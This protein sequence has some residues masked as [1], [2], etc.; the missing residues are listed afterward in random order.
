MIADATRS[1]AASILDANGRLPEQASALRSS[2]NSS[3]SLATTDPVVT[4]AM[5][6]ETPDGNFTYVEDAVWYVMKVVGFVQFQL[7]VADEAIVEVV[8]IES[9]G[10]TNQTQQ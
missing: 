5:A 6:A 3:N 4:V 2:I 9:V 8:K 7:V 1:L 10:L